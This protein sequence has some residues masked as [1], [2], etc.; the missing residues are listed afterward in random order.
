MID[1]ITQA[2]LP[3]GTSIRIG[4]PAEQPQEAIAALIKLFSEK[5]NVFSARLGLMEI[6][7]AD[8]PSEFTYTIGIECASGEGDIIK[9]AIVNA[10]RFEA[11]HG[12]QRDRLTVLLG[13]TAV[14]RAKPDGAGALVAVFEQG[15]PSVV[16]IQPQDLGHR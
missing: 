7:R 3:A 11:G 6:L 8:T 12:S 1:R 10:L 4:V 14:L 13:L 5:D 15:R 16:L 9:A 2:N